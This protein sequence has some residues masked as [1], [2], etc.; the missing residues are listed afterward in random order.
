MRTPVTLL[1]FFAGL[2]VLF[3]ISMS[4]GGSAASLFG[5]WGSASPD[6]DEE[7]GAGPGG[8]GAEGPEGHREP[9]GLSIA[10]RGYVV[11]PSMTRFQPGERTELRYN[12]FTTDREL[13]T[14]FAVKH[15]HQM[16]LVVVRRDMTQYQHLYPT[17]EPDGTWRVLLRL[18]EPGS[19]RAFAS[20]LPGKA[21]EPVTLGFDLEAPGLVESQ[22]VLS[23]STLS[24]TGDYSVML[25]GTVIAGG[26]A[27][28][29]TN[30]QRGTEQVTDLEPHLGHPGHLVMLREGDLAY[31]QVDPVAGSTVTGPTITFDVSVPTSGFYRVFLEFQHQGEVHIAQFT[32]LAS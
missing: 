19:Y 18:D 32:V 4:L 5:I 11:F 25:E 24:R 16:H 7:S 28:L 15:D 27:R 9:G 20:F 29:Y 26:V 21:K 31:L 12:I 2:V 17:L 8:Q 6:G 14:G 1:A 13:V 3:G 30:V 22:P 10:D 23:P